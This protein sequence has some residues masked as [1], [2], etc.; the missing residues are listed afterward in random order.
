MSTQK[1]LINPLSG[2]SRRFINSFLQVILIL[3]IPCSVKAVEESDIN[4]GLQS[5][6]SQSQWLEPAGVMLAADTDKDMVDS[7]VDESATS[8]DEVSA[9][10]DLDTFSPYNSF[11][12]ESGWVDQIWGRPS[13]IIFIWECG[14]CIWIL[15]MIRKI[16]TS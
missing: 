14:R 16:I 10:L 3:L 13:G 5:Q 12:Q 6:P 11:E 1:T 4:F 15:A 9:P 7:D 2:F 8:S